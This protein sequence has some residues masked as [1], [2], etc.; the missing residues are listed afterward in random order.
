MVS[1]DI[2]VTGDTEYEAVQN[3]DAD[4]RSVCVVAAEMMATMSPLK[5][6]LV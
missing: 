4:S 6:M 1:R 3:A 5:T 2:G